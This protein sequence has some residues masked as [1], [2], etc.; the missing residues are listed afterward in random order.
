MQQ[1]IIQ[2]FI[3]CQVWLILFDTNLITKNN[4]SF[5]ENRFKHALNHRQLCEIAIWTKKSFCLAFPVFFGGENFSGIPLRPVLISIYSSHTTTCLFGGWHATFHTSIVSEFRDEACNCHTPLFS[6][7]RS[8]YS[9]GHF[10]VLLHKS[11]FFTKKYKQ[12]SDLSLLSSLY[13]HFV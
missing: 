10:F 13:Y 12:N 8:L 3:L 7:C 6:L 4:I 2:H 5:R 9:R 1:K 11:W